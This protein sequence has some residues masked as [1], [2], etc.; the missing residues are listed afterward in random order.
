MGL[1]ERVARWVAPSVFKALG[2]RMTAEQLL[3]TVFGPAGAGTRIG[4]QEVLKAYSTMPWLRSVVTRTSWSVACV[5]WKLYVATNA[6]ASKQGKAVKRTDV[7]RSMDP[8]QRMKAYKALR[9]SDSLRE[10]ETHPALDL[11]DKGN[12]RFSGAICRQVTQQHLDLVGEG[13]W[14]LERNGMLLPSEILPIPPTW[15]VQT[16]WDRVSRD[17]WM[18]STPDRGT[19]TVP[20]DD[21]IYFHH[22]DPADPY[23]RGRGMGHALGD[24]L[25]TD[26]AITLHLK[27]WF[28]NYAMPP[29]IVSRKGAATG[30]TSQPANVERMEEAWMRKLAGRNNVPYFSNQELNIQTVDTTFKDMQLSDLRSDERDI[31]IHVYGVPPEIF[32]ILESSNRSTIDAADYILAKHVQVPRL[33]HMRMVLQLRLIERYDERLILD[34]VSPVMEDKEFQLKVVQGSPQAFTLDEIR[35][36]AGHR[37]LATGG[38]GFY[39]PMNTVYVTDPSE[40]GTQEAAVAAA[41][42]GAGGGA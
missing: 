13:A 39:V 5:P 42:A 8:N 4:T 14:L 2:T 10:I 32:G 1:R 27:R 18:I 31:L 16:P 15:I 3:Q 30:T 40:V 38:E 17:T 26:E 24:E 12:E 7:A 11:L 23:A 35:E 22:P 9:A 21:L 29:L 6:P 41:G 34:Y 25:E 37:P 36:L 28:K 19:L 33:E 20:K